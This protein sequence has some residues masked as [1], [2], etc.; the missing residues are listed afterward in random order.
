MTYTSQSEYC[1]TTLNVIC[2]QVKQYSE[3]FEIERRD[4]AQMAAKLDKLKRDFDT[5]R[6]ERDMAI[7]QVDDSTLE[8]S[9]L[10]P[11]FLIYAQILIQP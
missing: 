11:I 4:R 1:H 8:L 5:V 2:Y 6:T 3:D 10:L 7:Q 9:S